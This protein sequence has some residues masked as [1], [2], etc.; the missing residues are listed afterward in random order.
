[1]TKKSY[2]DGFLMSY[3]KFTTEHVKTVKNL[4]ILFKIQGFFF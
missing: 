3:Q 1:M 4:R 2:L